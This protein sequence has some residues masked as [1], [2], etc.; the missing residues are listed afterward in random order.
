MHRE[1]GRHLGRDAPVGG[2]ERR[3]RRA[4]RPIGEGPDRR[5]QAAGRERLCRAREAKLGREPVPGL[6]ADQQRHAPCRFPALEGTLHDLHRREGRAADPRHPRHLGVRLDRQHTEPRRQQRRQ[7][8]GAGADIDAS[9]AP[10]RRPRRAGGRSQPGD[11]RA[12]PGR[13]A[14]RRGRMPGAARRARALRRR[15]RRAAA[16][17]SRSARIGCVNSRSTG[18]SPG[19]PS[20]PNA[21]ASSLW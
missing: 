17:V 1:V 16:T 14:R 4:A 10:I 18:R 9:P 19:S 13:T 20:R 7:L 11:R 2:G 15:S 6:R 12:A 3:A 5:Q 21:A 8:A